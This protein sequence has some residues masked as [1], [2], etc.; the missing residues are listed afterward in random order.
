MKEPGDLRRR[1]TTGLECMEGPPLPCGQGVARV[2]TG[3]GDE[4][5]KKAG[6]SS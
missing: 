2:R 1:E 3:A 5:G 4:A 6:S